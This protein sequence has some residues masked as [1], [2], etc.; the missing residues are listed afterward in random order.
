MTGQTQL[1]PVVRHSGEGDKRWFFGGGEVTWKVSAADSG[2]AFLLFE[3][4]MQQGKVTPLHTHPT[5]ESFY[6][7][8][9]EI[10]VHLDGTEVAIKEGG[11]VL[12]PAGVPHA[13][14]VVSPSCRMLC[15]YS[16]GSCEAFYL[17]ASEP[18][19]ES[20]RQ[21]DFDRIMKSAKDSAGMTFLGPP[22]FA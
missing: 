17:G 6:V 1:A 8:E 12:A 14:K 16:S 5:D 2:G 11:F 9:G 10:L 13:F 18:L 22:P 20:S 3:D 7:L 19:A 4:A 15:F 21:V